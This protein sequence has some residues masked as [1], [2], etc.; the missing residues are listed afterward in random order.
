MA[1]SKSD[2]IIVVVWSLLLVGAAAINPAQGQTEALKFQKVA[3]WAPANRG[4]ARDIQVRD[5]LAFIAMDEGGLTIVDVAD[6]AKMRVIGRLNLP[7]TART[8]KLSGDFA[9]IPANANGLHIVN[10]ANPSAPLLAATFDTPGDALEVSLAGPYAFVA[11][12]T[13]GVV[14]L[15]VTNP[16][17]PTFVSRIAVAPQAYDVEAQS[18]QRSVGGVVGTHLYLQI[19]AG[20]N[21]LV[22]F[23]VTNPTAPVALLP[24]SG[25]PASCRNI[26]RSGNRCYFSSGVGVFYYEDGI[27]GSSDPIRPLAILSN[28]TPNS[29][30]GRLV[31][32]PGLL[33]S[34][35]HLF[36]GV[37]HISA[38]AFNSDTIGRFE[39][40][41]YSAAFVTNSSK[42]GFT[43]YYL[44]PRNG[45][46]VVS[47][48]ITNSLPIGGVAER[49][50]LAGDRIYLGDTQ[51]GIHILS[52][53]ASGAISH[54]STFYAGVQRNFDIINSNL[55]VLANTNA[56]ILD[57]ANPAQPS[58]VTNITSLVNT[59]TAPIRPIDALIH[60]GKAYI[61]SYELGIRVLDISNIAQPVRLKANN[62]GSNTRSLQV[63][64]TNLFAGA[65]QGFMSA[66]I[67]A[68]DDITR[69]QYFFTG[70]QVTKVQV[71]GSL[72]YVAD[73]DKGF[74]IFDVSNISDMKLL[75]TYDTPQDVVSFA[76]SGS[77]AFLADS[78]GG[79]IVVDISNPANL[80]RTGTLPLPQAA[81][82]V[83][84]SSNRIYVANGAG[85]LTVWEMVERLSQTIEF[86]A[87]PEATTRTPAFAISAVASSGLPVQLSVSGPAVFENGEI[88]TTGP[89]VVTITATQAGNSDYKPVQ[90]ERSFQV[91]EVPREPQQILL[92]PIADISTLDEPFYV[93]P[94]S[95]LGLPVI[96]SVT[97]PATWINGLLTT[98]GVG[99]VRINVTQEGTRDV[100][101]VALERVF[102]VRELN[103]AVIADVVAR[104]PQISA[105]LT[106]P[107]A[108]ADN[109]GIPNIVEFILRSDPTSATSMEGRATAQI[110]RS[111][112]QE[113]L[114]AIFTKPRLGGY[115]V[116]LE[117]T[118][119]NQRPLTWRAFPVSFDDTGTGSFLWPAIPGT[120]PVIRFVIQYP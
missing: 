61:S 23:R 70:K 76:I 85:G 100:A 53:Q 90:V 44:E 92:P 82:D 52:L 62:E 39:E 37:N 60:A 80:T 109:D 33:F 49:V 103:D 96:V 73:R 38:L 50:R 45:L 48:G 59:A 97:G 13:N 67:S 84:V 54:Q 22:A 101:P 66:T 40:D 34:T 111:D 27:F 104:N 77:Q 8:I 117:V 9:Y 15:N 43:E 17:N 119:L 99:E 32:E 14:V 3:S 19:A 74:K 20:T 115:P 21:D 63:I 98:T 93:N 89:G 116:Y 5:N 75:S 12:G 4:E 114:L 88:L 83:Q 107:N 65:S 47:G 64:G 28:F 102:R 51:Q 110:Y 16:V 108:D 2:H 41:A 113:Y 87:I 30:F 25:T 36:G 1:N 42:G 79:L 78:S 57:A 58:V 46:V 94:V 68:D 35:I 81:L 6:T 95:S 105:E 10:I 26:F 106:L 55:I 112:S 71:L 91:V 69:A 29:T 56:L 86:S 72:A 18:A 31:V 24:P 7:G 120:L 11:D 118:D